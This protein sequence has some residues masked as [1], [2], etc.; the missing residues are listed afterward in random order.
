MSKFRF[1]LGFADSLFHRS[2][3][4]R[5]GMV[6]EVKVAGRGWTVAL[7]LIPVFGGFAAIFVR[8][9]WLTA[10]MGE[11]YRSLS[12]G[13]RVRVVATKAARGLIFD[14]Q[15]RLLVANEPIYRIKKEGIKDGES[16]SYKFI[17]RGEALSLMA[18]GRETE[19]LEDVGRDYKYKVATSHLLG[20][21]GDASADEVK[22]GKYIV[23][24]RIGRTG[25]EQEYDQLLRGEDGAR[26][27][28]VDTGG[29]LLHEIG[30]K[31][32][33]PGENLRL[34]IDANLQEIAYGAFAGKPGALIAS[35]PV[36]GEVLALVSSPGFDP[37][38]FDGSEVSSAKVSQVFTDSL[39]PLFNRAIAGT[40]PPGSTFKVISAIA[41]LESGTIGRDF[42]YEDKGF[43]VLGDNKQSF[44]NWYFTQ[45]GRTEGSVGV[46]RAIARSTD[47]FFYRVGE[48]LGADKLSSW[49][50]NFGLGQLT[51]IDL[52]GEVSGLVP[53]PAWKL[54]VKGE[55]W[56]LGDTVIMAI[57]QG[58]LLTTPVQINRMT[59][60]IASGGM[61]CHLRLV[62]LSAGEKTDCGKLPI[63]EANRKLV[64]EG[65]YGACAEGGTAFPLFNFP[66]KENRI[67]VAC[68]TGTAEFGDPKNRTH[69]WLTAFVEEGVSRPYGRDPIVITAVV[70]AG[71][72]GSRA[73]APIVRKVLT[74]YFGVEDKYNYGAIVGNGE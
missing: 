58:N 44:S 27:V 13:N 8:L 62:G 23:G 32:P 7:F 53:D 20:Y 70:E 66:N 60:I 65:M 42:R 57:G 64:I 6:P 29:Q 40:Y 61:S 31:D 15:G 1:G 25:I 34:S 73:A 4:S 37:V 22:E 11:S 35:N 18:G 41:G 30:R 2:I 71:G 48:M 54:K 36:T 56:F 10:V 33:R 68:K 26:L 67:P 74:G 14:K 49:A 55:R 51:R 46:S 38:L 9:V 3:S 59:A 24:D 12:D 5:K 21:V 16:P 45:Y 19:V 72:E 17:L 47:T 63:E 39:R 28:E 52:P 69:A 50:R 43:V